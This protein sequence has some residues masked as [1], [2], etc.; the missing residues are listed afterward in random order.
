[1]ERSAYLRLLADDERSGT[2]AGKDLNF[3]FADIHPE[4]AKPNSASAPTCPSR[5]SNLSV[6]PLA[7]RGQRVYVVLGYRGHKHM[8]KPSDLVQGTLDMLLLKIL[9]LEPMNGF[10]V[11][12]RLK[13]V[14]GDVLQMSDGSLYP[15][16][17]KLE[18]EGWVT[19]EW[20]TS[21]NGR[22][23][24]YYSL[25]RLGRRQLEK[26]TDNWGRLS[27]AISRVVKLK[28]A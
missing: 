25:T 13:Q 20:K 18:Q 3:R 7:Y 22:R 24:K 15:A 8:S 27:S 5:N 23:A 26:E 14:S 10:A 9:A 28:E 2:Y 1:M 11:S 16:L 17:H 6:C 4:L 12:Q 19:A 21:I